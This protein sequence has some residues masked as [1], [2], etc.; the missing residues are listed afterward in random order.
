MR[1]GVN[2]EAGRPHELRSKSSRIRLQRDRLPLN[3]TNPVRTESQEFSS[4]FPYLRIV[5]P[6]QL[7]AELACDEIT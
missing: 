5:D 7:L 3:L 2:A 6:V 1:C 4:R